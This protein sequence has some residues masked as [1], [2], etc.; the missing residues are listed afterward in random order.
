MSLL[1][2]KELRESCPNDSRLAF[3]VKSGR[4]LRKLVIEIC[5]SFG[6]NL[7]ELTLSSEHYGNI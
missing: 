2:L 3:G 7:K 4:R 5:I 1:G 6:G